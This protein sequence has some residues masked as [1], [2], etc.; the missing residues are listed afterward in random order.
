MRGISILVKPS[1]GKCNLGCKY[2]FY[3]DVTENRNVP[4]F[5]MMSSKT[6]ETLVRKAIS[7]NVDEIT[8]AF[9]GGEPTLVRLNFYQDLI[10]FVN[11]YNKNGIKVNYA[12]Q[13]NG[14]MIDEKWTRFFSE[15]KFLV[16][17]SIDGTKEIH[18]Q[19][20]VD[21]KG[22]GTYNRVI[23]ATRLMDKYKVDYNV[24]IVVTKNVVRH[25]TKIY[26]S[27][28]K[29]GFSY[30]QFIPCLDELGSE[31]GSH[32]YS[33]SPQDYGRF[34]D[35]LFIAWYNDLIAGE[36]ISIRMFDNLIGMSMGYAAESC[37]MKQGCSVNL[38]VEADGSAY[39]CDFYVL[40]EWKIGNVVEE[41][42]ETMLSSNIG[43]KFVLDSIEL[44]KGCQGCKY[45]RFCQGGC[46][47]HSDGT[48]LYYCDSYKYFYEKN[49]GKINELAYRLSR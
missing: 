33:L 10:E 29:Q 9:Q 16:G 44:I 45:F 15:N 26:N 40:D 23:K 37:D 3:N 34:L 6:L 24:L 12:I 43:K 46:K 1:S 17:I 35:M 4:D 36:K 27:L 21:H 25:L 22:K 47:R 38:V 18:D 7:M 28:K 30:M 31:P 14:M 32:A 5:G 19:N 42:L 39:P 11:R 20:R 2:C 49:M 13:T 8:F 48:N 41:N